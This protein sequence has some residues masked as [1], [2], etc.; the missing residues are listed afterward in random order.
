MNSRVF[1]ISPT[2]PSSP[3]SARPSPK[4][5]REEMAKIV[6]ARLPQRRIVLPDTEES[7][8]ARR[9]P[10]MK[11]GFKI[12]AKF[13]GPEAECVLEA[14]NTLI[15]NALEQCKTPEGPRRIKWRSDLV[16]LWIRYDADGPA[17]QFLTLAGF[18]YIKH[19]HSQ[20]YHVPMWARPEKRGVVKRLLGVAHATL[21][22]HIAQV[23]EA[24]QAARNLKNREECLEKGRW[25]NA[26][27]ASEADRRRVK[28]RC[29]REKGARQSAP[30][31]A[32]GGG[33]IGTRTG[34]ESPL[35]FSDGEEF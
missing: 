30:E 24:I 6:A 5:S 32:W 15:S 18:G 21:Q 17:E 26:L 12:R 9:E 1:S 16:K 19:E 11:L 2:L 8:E 31:K 13:E 22:E 28:E 34:S 14:L 7:V 4:I 3:Q 10:L 23:K 27:R 33:A 25:E 29:E 35:S 20:Y